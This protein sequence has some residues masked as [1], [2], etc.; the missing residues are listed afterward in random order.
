MVIFKPHSTPRTAEAA[1]KSCD[2]LEGC[3]FIKL[4]KESWSY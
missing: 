4:L 2:E 3:K 1:E